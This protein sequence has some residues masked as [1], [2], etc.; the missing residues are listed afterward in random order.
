MEKFSQS[1]IRGP[2]F[3]V[4]LFVVGDWDLGQ[5][6]CCERWWTR[7]LWKYFVDPQSLAELL[8]RVVK[9]YVLQRIQLTL[10]NP[11]VHMSSPLLKYV[12]G[13]EQGPLLEAHCVPFSG[14]W[15]PRLH[16]PLSLAGIRDGPILAWSL[17]RQGHADLSAEPW[18]PQLGLV[19]WLSH[20]LGWD[21]LGISFQWQASAW[22]LWG[23]HHFA[24]FLGVQGG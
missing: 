14:F 15:A 21:M 10:H 16:A 3:K 19:C 22:E 23:A 13:W 18:S 11:G 4:C 17:C 1:E 8:G 9:C 5:W 7:K 24:K 6:H 12:Q 20:S 2:E